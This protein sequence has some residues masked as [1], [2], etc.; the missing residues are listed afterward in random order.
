M[1]CMAMLKEIDAE[2]VEYLCDSMAGRAAFLTAVVAK[3]AAWP[4]IEQ[5]LAEAR[6][7]LDNLTEAYND[8]ERDV[9]RRYAPEIA[10]SEEP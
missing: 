10:A 3:Q 2:V 6:R 1:V 9:E 5:C 8:F 4:H 7:C